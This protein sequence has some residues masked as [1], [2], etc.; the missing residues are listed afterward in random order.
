MRMHMTPMQN[1]NPGERAVHGASFVVRRHRLAATTI[2][3]RVPRKE[4]R[5]HVGAVFKHAC[6]ILLDGGDVVALLA[7]P[8]GQVAHGVRLAEDEPMDRWVRNGMP[9]RICGGE[10]V[11]GADVAVTLSSG[12]IWTPALRL[13]MCEWNKIT[14][15]AMGLA[16]NVLLDRAPASSSEFL[17]AALHTAHPVT[18]LGAWVSRVLPRLA[19]AAGVYDANRALLCL[20]ELIGLGPGLTPAG[21][22]FT[23]GWLAGLTLGAQSPVQRQFLAAMCAGIEKLSLTTTPISRQHLGDAC[24]LMFSERLSAVC[25]AIADGASRSALESSMAAQ[26]AVGATSGADAAAGLMFALFDCGSRRQF[27]EL[28]GRV[29]WLHRTE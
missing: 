18:A 2:G 27:C 9:A 12:Q 7:P 10:I 19:G 22:D 13:G 11:L 25:V 5:G 28:P 8:I 16:R 3:C 20:R 29:S 6:I 26:L 4:R 1:T 17:A 23:I 21:D 24:T 14:L 15:K